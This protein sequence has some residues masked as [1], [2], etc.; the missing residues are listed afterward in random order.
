MILKYKLGGNSNMNDKFKNN[1]KSNIKSNIKNENETSI[2]DTN[3]NTNDQADPI[4]Q[5]V[6]TFKIGKKQEDK[7]EKVQ[8]PLYTF[9]PTVKELDKIVKKT[10]YSRNELIN[11]MID[12]C[13]KNI[14]FTDN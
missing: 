6:T 10:G 13:I 9:K 11:M 8:F 1:L 2:A 12:F 14:E 3:I 4:D 5:P 7:N